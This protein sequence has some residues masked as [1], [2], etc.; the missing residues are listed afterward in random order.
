M[1]TVKSILSSLEM[2]I[3]SETAEGLSL[4]VPVYRIDVRRDVDVIDRK[5][6]DV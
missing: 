2:E 6:L 5:V 3:V 1:E 4:R